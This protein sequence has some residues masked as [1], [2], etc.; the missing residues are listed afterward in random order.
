[1]KPVGIVGSEA[2]NYMNKSESIISR[3]IGAAFGLLLAA[4]GLY[5]AAH[6]LLAVWPILLAAA[7]IA[8][9]TVGLVAWLRAR[10]GAW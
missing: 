5:W 3:I 10:W 7:V 1:M 8:F 9:C 6:L 4:L 2:P